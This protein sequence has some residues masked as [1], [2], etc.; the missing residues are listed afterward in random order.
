MAKIHQ[1]INII[2]LTESEVWFKCNDVLSYGHFELEYPTNVMITLVYDKDT[3]GLITSVNGENCYQGIF[4][5]LDE[6]GK[7]EIRKMVNQIFFTDLINQ[8][9]LESLEYEKVTKEALDKKLNEL[10][11]MK[12]LL[13][14]A[15]IKKSS[16]G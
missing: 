10:E 13:E 4:H 12:K 15:E 3:G 6:D 14:M 11:E 5:C 7:K 1:P 2:A 9:K 16:N 8:R